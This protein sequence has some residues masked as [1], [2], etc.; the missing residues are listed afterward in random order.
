[1]KY[2]RVDSFPFEFE[3]SGIIFRWKS[4]G[5]PDHIPLNLTENMKNK[6]IFLSA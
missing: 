2:K 6:S 4:K 1:M 3:P 5:K